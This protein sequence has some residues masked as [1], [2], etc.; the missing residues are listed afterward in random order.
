[1]SQS[2]YVCGKPW[3]RRYQPVPAEPKIRLVCFP[4]AGGTPGIFR[5]WSARLPGYV[6]LL[7][8]CY[9][10]RQDRITEPCL[11]RMEPLADGIADAVVSLPDMPL[12][13]FGHSM[14]ALIAYEVAVRMQQR[15][16]RVPAKLFLSAHMTP[17]RMEPA[18]EYLHQDDA[19]ITEVL[20]AGGIAPEILDNAELRD[21]MMPFIRAD[22]HLLASYRPS[23]MTAVNIPI[24]GYLGLDDPFV[25]VDGVTAW[26]EITTAGFELRTF[27]GQHFYLESEEAALVAD[28]LRH[29]DS[30]CSAL[31]T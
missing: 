19:L 29:L 1:V 27:P 18:N 8:V 23:S 14:G 21:L 16:H 26:A 28:I 4:H 24:V 22:Y 6:E 2:N 5:T 25:D 10:G 12:A 20:R 11:D 31:P 13:L 7:A 17:D 9:P 15:H 3:F 30:V